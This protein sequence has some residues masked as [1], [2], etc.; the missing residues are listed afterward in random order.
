[1][2]FL[3]NTISCF[4]KQDSLRIV[5]GVYTA[6][7]LKRCSSSAIIIIIVV[8]YILPSMCMVLYRVTASIFN[9]YNNP[10]R[11]ARVK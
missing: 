5:S 9:P 7:K 2:H 11:R 4:G 1:M 3:R 6:N 10:V 8:V